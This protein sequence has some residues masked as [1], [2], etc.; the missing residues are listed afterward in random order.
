MRFD[1][2]SKK[3]RSLR[4]CE[5]HVTI[6][7][8]SFRGLA[9]FEGE[10]GYG[11]AVRHQA[12]GRMFI[13]GI[14]D[15]REP[16]RPPEPPHGKPKRRQVALASCRPDSEDEY[17]AFA[18]RAGHGAFHLASRFE[19][20]DGMSIWRQVLVERPAR[21][22]AYAN[23]LSSATLEPGA[24]FAGTGTFADKSLSGDLAASYLGSTAPVPVTPAK[25]RLTKEP[26]L[27][28]GI[29]CGGGFSIVW[30]F[31]RRAGAGT[32]RAVAAHPTAT[33]RRS[34]IARAGALPPA[35]RPLAVLDRR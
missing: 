25:A 10:G 7:S 13:D 5:G 16:E 6:L 27:S 1:A 12:T 35:L 28:A 32:A 22:F 29:G 30:I 3:R 17:Y 15:C 14:H 11:E 24:P 20:H 8:G 9:W 31:P 2:K 26:G 23:D 34:A 33:V 4:F 19:H 21:S 18:A